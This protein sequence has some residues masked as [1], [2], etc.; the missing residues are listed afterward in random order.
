[1]TLNEFNYSSKK[2]SKNTTQETNI[3]QLLIKLAIPFTEQYTIPLS[4][5]KYIIDFFI[6]DKLILEC[7]ATTMSNCHISLRKKAVSLEAKCSRI[8]KYFPYQFFVLFE[9][10]RSIGPHLFSSLLD[11]MPSI[12]FLFLSQKLLFEFLVEFFRK[13]S[14]SPKMTPPSS[15]PLS[16][17]NQNGDFS[18]NKVEN[19]CIDTKKSLLK[20][21]NTSS[22]LIT[23]YSENSS[24]LN[25]HSNPKQICSLNVKKRFLGEYKEKKEIHNE[26]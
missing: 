11:D 12:D 8:K 13:K 25:Q 10:D 15:F 17:I 3:R 7:S 4:N 19:Y 1:M 9:S 23:D 14:K 16:S 6:A 2:I 5:R 21:S 26:G 22:Y 18:V 20:D 24:F